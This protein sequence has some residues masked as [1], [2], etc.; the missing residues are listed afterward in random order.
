MV[1]VKKLSAKEK[2]KR[3]AEVKQI[4]YSIRQ[5]PELKRRIREALLAQ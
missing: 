4:L 3:I 1:K 5:Q 2:Q